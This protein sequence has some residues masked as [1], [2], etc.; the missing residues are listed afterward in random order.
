MA[1]TTPVC[2][3][4]ERRPGGL[5]WLG[6]CL[7]LALPAARAD[8]FTIG[9]IDTRL[10]EGVYR[11]SATI[12]YRFSDKALQALRS[13]VPLTVLLNI[14][15]ERKRGWW[16][17]DETIAS[18]EQR[19]LLQ[20]HALSGQY[21][22]L[23]INSGAIHTYP[24]ERSAIEALGVIRDFPL[25][26]AR[27]IRAEAEYEIEL[28]AELDIEALPAPLRPVAYLSP[29]WRLASDWYAWSLTP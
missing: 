5:A 22:I 8:E 20:F 1:F 16:W 13:G 6:L 12:D 27:L 14:D 23:N 18:L 26:D 25:L 21:L 19:Y 17:V 9:A 3:R 10:Q 11:L 29:S 4:R 28:K 15:V 2:A 24:G 7:L